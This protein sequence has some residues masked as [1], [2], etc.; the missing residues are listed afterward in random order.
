MCVQVFFPLKNGKLS[1]V[2]PLAPLSRA[3]PE[4]G[5]PLPGKVPLRCGV[6]PLGIRGG[7]L[8]A[9]RMEEIEGAGVNAT[10]RFPKFVFKQR[11]PRVSSS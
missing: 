6:A 8:H 11:P 5:V 7:A 2:R 4:G 1:L 10:N 3:V 9:D